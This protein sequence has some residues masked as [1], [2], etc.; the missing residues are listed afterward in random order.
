MLSSA[1]RFLDRIAVGVA[2]AACVAFAVLITWELAGPFDA[3]HDAATAAIGIAAVNMARWE[4]V[5]PVVHFS[6][7]VP[8][9]AAYY[10]HHPWGI[11]WTTALL[12]RCFGPHDWVLRIAPVAM[13]I[14]TPVLVFLAARRLYGVPAAAVAAVAFVV[15]PISLAF[16]DFNALEVPVM[17]GIAAGIWG[18]VRFSERWRWRWLAVALLGLCH[19]M[20]SDWAAFVFV[21]FVLGAALLR[22]TLLAGSGF[23]PYDLGRGAVAWASLAVLAVAIGGAYVAGFASLGQLE[24]LIDQGAARAAG[25]GTSWLLLL[26]RRRHWLELC[27][28]PVGFALG[29]LAFPIL[30][31]RVAWLRRQLDLLPLGVL[32]MALFQYLV[33]KNGAD[34]HVFWP[35]YF[36]LYLA[37]GAGAL[38]ATLTEVATRLADYGRKTKHIHR[39][40]VAARVAFVGGLLPLLVM[41]PDALATLA[42]ARRTGKRFDDG[43]RL[44]TEDGDKHAVARELAGRLGSESRVGVH[45]SMHLDWSLEWALGRPV[46]ERV[47]P[48][49]GVDVLLVDTRFAHPG[50]LAATVR[51]Q[52]VTAYGPFWVAENARPWRPLTAFRFTRSEPGALRWY[53]VDGND[54]RFGF[55]PDPFSTWE[56][57]EYFGQ[58]PNPPPALPPRTS[59]ELRIAHGIALGAGDVAVADRHL[60]E[61]L[62]RLD[63]RPRTAYA[64]GSELLGFELVPGVAPLLRVYVQTGATPRGHELELRIVSR[65]DRRPW[66]TVA[67]P[68]RDRLVGLPFAI[69]PTFFRPR[70]VY[71]AESEIRRQPGRDAYTAELVGAG[72]PVGV[73]TPRRPLFELP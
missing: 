45:R 4:I 9:P 33:F 1:D 21:A 72:A 27:F 52:R 57:R 15:T 17:F 67:A 55:E 47:A 11:F 51:E 66:S 36:A 34:V 38:V 64:D 39:R 8:L 31:F 44:I 7:V 24:R 50:F 40:R 10:C 61:L 37:Y 65:V 53:W 63:Q 35:H 3:G 42:Y 23:A 5:A 56:L 62:S 69:P 58:S 29:G 13:S 73:N 43:W 26:S 32:A 22:A 30:V 19:A 16:A 59:D 46:T 41:A 70:H 48:A 14:A 12:V 60:A 49:E 54:P 28:T 2:V 20:N 71:V 68:R 25:A 6:P 18:L